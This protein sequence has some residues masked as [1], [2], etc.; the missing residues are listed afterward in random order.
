MFPYKWVVAE[1]GAFIVLC[2]LTHIINLWTYQESAANAIRTMTFFKVTTAF[3]SCATAVTLSWVIPD[4]LSVKKREIYLV[5]KVSINQSIPVTYV[6]LLWELRAE[7]WEG[8]GGVGCTQTAELHMQVGAMKKKAETGENVCTLTS[9]I[10]STLNRHTILKT[11]LVELAQTLKLDNCNIW[12]P[13]D[14]G[15]NYKLMHELDEKIFSSAASDTSVPR[16]DS[17]VQ[18]VKPLRT[19][20]FRIS[21]RAVMLRFRVV[22]FCVGSEREWSGPGSSR[23]SLRTAQLSRYRGCQLG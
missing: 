10:R 5:G 13:T 16:T 23:L 7:S 4:V 19:C 1:F 6:L 21:N 12:M 15:E 18:F 17:G 20:S 8:R 3:V 14:D 11:T 2:G 9:E 22:G